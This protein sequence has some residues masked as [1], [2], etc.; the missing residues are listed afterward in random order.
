MPSSNISNKNIDTDIMQQ[1]AAKLDGKTK[2]LGS[3]GR[4]EKIAIQLCGIQQSLSPSVAKKRMLVFAASHGIAAEGVSAFPSEVTAQMVLNFLHGGAA[5]NVL[6]KHGE[7]DLQVID[8]GV[9]TEFDSHVRNAEN[10]FSHKIAHGTKNFL[11][12]PAMTAAQCD[13]AIAAGRDQVTLARKNGIDLLGIGEMGIGNTTAASALYTA[14]LG[15]SPDAV[16]GRGTGIDDDRLR[17][18]IAVITNALQ[19]HQTPSASPLHWLIS[20]GGFEIAAMTG[21]ILECDAQRLPVVVDGFIA[22]AAAAAAF[23]MKPRAKEVCFFAHTSDEH[24]HKL[25]LQKL[26]VTPLLDLQMRLG[27]GTGAALAMHLIDGAAKI[28]CEMASFETAG[29]SGKE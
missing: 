4:L 23:A 6:C 24:A 22:T 9:D 7:I 29:V 12:E 11:H 8:V 18:K 16:A 19:R 26:G 15:I 13:D 28:L 3:L 10:F 5:I 21:V 14:L 20:V 2:P 17:R 25:V 27:E 1:A